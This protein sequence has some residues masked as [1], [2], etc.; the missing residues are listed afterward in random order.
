VIY[1]FALGALLWLLFAPMRLKNLS[2]IHLVTLIGMTAPL[3]FLYAVPVER[4]VA[5]ETAQS[6]NAWFLAI[7]ALWRVAIYFRY[8][9]V[10]LESPIWVTIVVGLLPLCGIVTAL[11]SMNLEKAVFQIMAGLHPAAPT[12]A[13]G[14]YQIVVLLTALSTMA[15]PF[16]GLGYVALVLRRCSHRGDAVAQQE[17]PPDQS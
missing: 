3:A 1:I 9:I 14:A 4:F 2:Y 6:I 12:A 10:Y 7:V 13:D 17:L 11:A 8:L 5:I 16:L 15:A